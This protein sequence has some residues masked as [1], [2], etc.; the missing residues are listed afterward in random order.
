MN[1]RRL[2]KTEL[3]VS[4]VGIGTWSFGG[5]T[6]LGNVPIGWGDVDDNDSIKTLQTCID[7]GVNLVDTADNYGMGHSEEIVGK[8]IKGYRDKVIL[9]SKGGNCEDENGN[10]IQRW[11]ADYIRQAVENSL[12]RLQTDYLDLY[13]IHTPNPERGKFEFRAETFAIFEE[14]KKEGK[15]LHY[16]YSANNSEDALKVIETGFCDVIQIVYN[17]LDRSP[18]EKL[19]PA[20]VK[21]D[22]GIMARVPL[23]SGFLSGKFNRNTRFEANDHRVRLPIEEIEAR[24]ERVDKLKDFA[25]IRGQSL[26]QFALRFCLTHDAVS[27]VIPGAKNPEQAMKNITA[28]DYGRLL[29]EELA[30]I[31]K[32]LAD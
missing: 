19:F 17:L 29:P 9:V 1:Y 7:N 5:P 27:T 21:N 2:G 16:G 25:D 10:W 24:V 4:E 6:L 3:M 22:I 30:H 26:A 23:A 13:L 11:D 31:E 14:L 12:T 32:L 28:S 15:I 18:E 8:T 20:A